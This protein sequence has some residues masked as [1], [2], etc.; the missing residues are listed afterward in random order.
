V[1]EAGEQPGQGIACVALLLSA[2]VAGYLVRP[3]TAQ[4]AKTIRIAFLQ[5]EQLARVKRPGTTPRDAIRALPAGPTVADSTLPSREPP[6]HPGS[7]RPQLALA[8]A[9]LRT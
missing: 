1:K 3:A 9:D 5:G 4:P 2:G 8:R 7:R 6:G